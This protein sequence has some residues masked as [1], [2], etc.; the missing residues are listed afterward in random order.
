MKAVIVSAST[1][2]VL[3][4]TSLAPVMAQSQSITCLKEG[5][6]I[7]C[8]GYGRFEYTADSRYNRESDLNNL[9]L[10]VLARNATKNELRDFKKTMNNQGWSLV[11]VRENLV[12]SEEFYQSINRFYQESLGRNIDDNSLKN[13]R[14]VVING[15]NLGDIR[16]EIS[17]STEAR[18]RNNNNYNNGNYNQGNYNSSQ[19]QQLNELYVQVLGRNVNS[20]DLDNYNRSINRNRNYSLVDARRDLVNSQQFQQAINNLY[21]QYLGRNADSAGLQSYR[22]TIIAGSTFDNIRNEISNSPEARQYQGN[23]N[24]N[25]TNNSSG[26]TSIIKGILCGVTNV[27]LQ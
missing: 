18:N 13:Y 14:N 15:R 25:N 26:G 6:F 27:C 24:I 20:S 12:N 17:N 4:L 3:S 16:N 2:L 9:F 8:P 23:N 1:L 11:Q 21:Q 19:Q 5:N 22:N 7:T 10:Q